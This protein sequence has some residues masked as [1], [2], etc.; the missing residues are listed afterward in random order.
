MKVF[1][2]SLG[3][4]S[5]PALDEFDV[6]VKIPLTSVSWATVRALVTLTMFLLCS[7]CA[8]TLT[9]GRRPDPDVDLRPFIGQ[10]LTIRGKFTAAG[11]PGPYI[12]ARAGPVYLVPH[13]SFV[14]ES[15][16]QRMQGKTVSVT[17]TLRFQD[18][19]PS[20]IGDAVQ[21]SPD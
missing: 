18:S 3:Q 16:Y 4:S 14:W 5:P 11:K 20:I 19:K 8:Y 17:G 2:Q 13:G 15:D 21:Q 10:I 7:G 6:E 1:L 9:G 12:Q